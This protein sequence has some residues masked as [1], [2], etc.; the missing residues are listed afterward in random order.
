MYQS[1]KSNDLVK[2]SNTRHILG[3]TERALHIRVGQTM[4][5]EPITAFFPK[6]ACKTRGDGKGGVDIYVPRHL[7]RGHQ[8][9]IGE[10][11][12]N[13]VGSY[14][15]FEDWPTGQDF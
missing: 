11:A 4:Y 14:A 12:Q 15:G 8:C 7:M 10:T 6:V 5:G 9:Y 2:V 13:H 3:E 1:Q